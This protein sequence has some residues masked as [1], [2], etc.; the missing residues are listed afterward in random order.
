MQRLPAV[1]VGLKAEPGNENQKNIGMW[2]VSQRPQGAHSIALVIM[3]DLSEEIGRNVQRRIVLETK[4]SSVNGLDR[5]SFERLH[6]VDMLGESGDNA[7]GSPP[8]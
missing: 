4:S 8:A 5:F 6:L 2:L 7:H 3:R 1:I